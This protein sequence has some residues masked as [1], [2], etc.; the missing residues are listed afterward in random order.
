MSGDMG[1]AV[2]TLVE[3]KSKGASVLRLYA[4]LDHLVPNSYVLK[5]FII[6]FVGTHVPLLC[7]ASFLLATQ[8]GESFPWRIIAVVLLA[9]IFGFT[10]TL[11][12]LN[13]VLAPVM[14][15]SRAAQAYR[16]SRTV[17]QLPRIYGD[18]V[19]SLMREV[20]SLIERPEAEL[21][22]SEEISIVDPL[23]GLKNRRGLELALQDFRTKQVRGLMAV[24]D[25]DHFKLV[26]DTFG[27]QVGDEVLVNVAG[28]IARVTRKTD[29]AARL[30]GDEFIVVM[31]REDTDSSEIARRLK[32]ELSEIVVPGSSNPMVC[33]V[34]TA[35]LTNDCSL[36]EAFA[37]ADHA[38]LALKR[39]RGR[40]P[41]VWPAKSEE[42]VG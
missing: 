9:T 8:G 22:A 12:L 42:A 32:K 6:A 27:H 15:V 7:L 16:H 17:P 39:N 19:G 40:G 21:A 25:C 38:L 31:P 10:A 33:S 1:L 28:A 30:G 4:W 34:G 29:I 35:E 13:Q 23:T 3:F 20:Q 18:E 37:A 41:T 11:I 5:A 14:A 36:G 2:A 24:I 26:N